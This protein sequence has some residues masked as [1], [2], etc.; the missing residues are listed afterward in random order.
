MFSRYLFKPLWILADLNYHI[1]FIFNSSPTVCIIWLNVG[2][3]EEMYV[4]SYM[5]LWQLHS[6]SQTGPVWDRPG[7]LEWRNNDKDTYA[8]FVMDLY[9]IQWRWV[10]CGMHLLLMANFD[11]GFLMH[12]ALVIPHVI[13][14]HI[15]KKGEGWNEGRKVLYSSIM[16]LQLTNRWG[17][18]GLGGKGAF[19]VWVTDDD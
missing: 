15:W 13:Q 19:H 18:W 2:Q 16:A 11:V 17:R 6:Q 3:N 8:C 9:V 4:D 7:A 12:L 1:I 14:S 5:Q 10:C